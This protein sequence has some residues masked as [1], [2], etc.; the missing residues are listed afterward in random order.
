MKILCL[1]CL[2]F[3]TGPDKPSDVFIEVRP[4]E[5]NEEVVGCREDTFVSKMIMSILNEMKAFKGLRDQ[6][7]LSVT[8]LPK[9][10]AINHEVV[11][12][13]SNELSI[14]IIAKRRG[15]S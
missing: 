5:M 1:A 8:N 15:I 14:F 7:G 12:G 10:L 13:L 6:L 11:R 3:V 9:H 2:A 4:P